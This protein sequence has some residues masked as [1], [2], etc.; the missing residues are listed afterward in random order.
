MEENL[1]TKSLLEILPVA[2]CV[3]D[4]NGISIFENKAY[5]NMIRRSSKEV[6]FES[7]PFL[8][9]KIVVYHDISEV[10]HLRREL[11]KLNQRLR[12]AEVKYTFSDIIGNA[13]PLLHTIKIAKGAALTPATVLLRG[14]SGTGK[15][16]FAHAIHNYS[17][18]RNRPFVKINCTSLPDTLLESELFGYVDGAFTGARRGGKKGLFQEANQGTL[19]LDEIGDISPAM[20]IKL[21]RVLQEK[22]IMPVGAS[23][24]VPLDVR[25]ICATHRN[26]EEMI[27]NGTFREDLYYRLNVFPLFLTPLRERQEDIGAISLY[28]LNLHNPQYGRHVEEIEPAALA[29]LKKQPW[30]GNVRELENILARAMIYLPEQERTLRKEALLPLLS[31]MSAEAPPQGKLQ[32]LADA[33]ES[34]ERACIANALLKYEQNKNKAAFELDI[35][36]RTLY[37]KCKKLGLQ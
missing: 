29:L 9:G 17:P 14:E 1:F 7:I 4:M 28:L 36:L 35:S 34:A 18:R 16:I 23:Q 3:F 8:Y 24:T 33:I 20:Q 12:N 6:I 19:F 15:E 22:E 32:K 2:V 25:I 13:P 27:E 21:L 30:R 37:Y 10:N 11:E 31:K 5:Q 26:L